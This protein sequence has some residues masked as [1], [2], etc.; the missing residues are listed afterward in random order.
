M[1]GK[2]SAMARTHPLPY[3]W[4]A[5]RILAAVCQKRVVAGAPSFFSMWS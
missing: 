3:F 1:L 2:G 4:A 5:A